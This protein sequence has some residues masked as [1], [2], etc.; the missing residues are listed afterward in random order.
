MS[1][2]K[3]K[4]GWTIAIMVL[5]IGVGIGYY[6]TALSLYEPSEDL[7]GFPIPK[8]AELVQESNKSKS[9]DWSRASEENGIPFDYE[10]AL[11][12][13]GW[14]KG[15]REGTSVSYTKGNHTIDLLSSTKWLDI[16][17]IK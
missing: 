7:Y 11:K 3:K 10:I 17:K 1:V 2:I 8:N 4:V 14:K 13:N 9:Y 5:L 16:I 6:F 15:E 12:A